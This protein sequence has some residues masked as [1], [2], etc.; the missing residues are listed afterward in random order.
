MSTSGLGGDDIVLTIGRKGRK[1]NGLTPYR[2]VHL[3]AF[4]QSSCLRKQAWKSWDFLS[5]EKITCHFCVLLRSGK[6][7]D[8]FPCHKQELWLHCRDMFF[9]AFSYF[10]ALDENLTS[11]HL[12]LLVWVLTQL[13]FMT[14]CH[15]KLFWKHKPDMVV[16][17]QENVSG[18]WSILSVSQNSYLDSIWL[19]VYL[20]NYYWV[21]GGQQ[22]MRHKKV[23]V[24][25]AD[26][27]TS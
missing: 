5:K 11:I 3:A 17:M 16:E 13:R 14:K 20:Y 23:M 2:I 18:N 7:K 1:Y 12:K 8:G 19:I 21:E 6:A 9:Q 22:K 27:F 10:M 15:A 25:C 24:G 4:W 26:L